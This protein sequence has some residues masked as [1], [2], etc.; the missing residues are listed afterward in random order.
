MLA[1]LQATHV[2]QA[3]SK[4]HSSATTV[5]LEDNVNFSNSTTRIFQSFDTYFNTITAEA[6]QI[7]PFV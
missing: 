2:S 3:S 1:H 5:T 7:N 4:V 6:P